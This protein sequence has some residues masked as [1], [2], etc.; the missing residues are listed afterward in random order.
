MAAQS[1]LINIDGLSHTF[2]S[3]PTALHVLR[4]VKLQFYPG[5]ITIIVGPSGSGK[6]TI[7]T[8]AGA[9]RS[10]QAGVVEVLGQE[11][12][13]AS[14]DQ[15]W[16]VRRQIGFIFQHHN[17]LGSLTARENVQMGLA[18]ETNTPAAESQ[19]RALEMLDRVG[20]AAHAHKYPDQLSGG[21]RQRVAIA[22]ALVRNPK[23]IM[24]DEP[25]AA[26]DSQSGREVVGLLQKLAREQGCAIMMVTHDNRIL[27]IA[28][29]IISLEDGH[30]EENHIALQRIGQQ[31]ITVLQS[32]AR[33]L[34]LIQ[35]GQHDAYQ[36]L[37]AEVHEQLSTDQRQTQQLA[38][39]ELSERVRAETDQLVAAV[40]Q[41]QQT[42]AAVRQFIDLIEP[43]GLIGGGSTSDRLFQSLNFLLMTA[44]DA[45]AS[46]EVEDIEALIQMTSDR[47]SLMDSL[48]QRSQDDDQSLVFDLTIAFARAVYFLHA[49]AKGWRSRVVDTA[50]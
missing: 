49:L 40:E 32:V 25:T 31:L 5:E 18:H 15:Q 10:V 50:A 46:D 41:L 13:G 26:L 42:E 37:I 29:R 35:G 33:Y 48:R 6:T 9:L 21:Q 2:G 27:D 20:L 47:G 22:R 44:A 24:A 1:A 30:I 39:R 7:L 11:L 4:S 45:L 14:A 17:L 19:Q 16:Q 43:S 3:G 34:D 23:L 28:D 12:N 38:V 36:Q 8:L